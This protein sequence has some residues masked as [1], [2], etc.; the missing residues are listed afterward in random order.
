MAVETTRETAG[1]ESQGAAAASD[2][3]MQRMLKIA[4]IAMA[5]LIALGLLAVVGRMI[6]LAS[7]RGQQ[8]AIVSGAVTTGARLPLPDGAQVRSISLSGDRLAVQYDAPS[9]AGIAVIDL[10]TGRPLTRVELTP[11]PPRR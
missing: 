2:A 9:G 4:I 6:Y 5:V 1:R 8:A 11:E 10:A 3:A 7:A